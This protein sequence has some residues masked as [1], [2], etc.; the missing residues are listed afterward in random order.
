MRVDGDPANVLATAK[1]VRACW[2]EMSCGRR[3]DFHQEF[4]DS[5]AARCDLH[6]Y[7][8]GPRE[9]ERAGAV[10]RRRGR[11]ESSEG[12][13]LTL[14]GVQGSPFYPLRHLHLTK[15]GHEY[16]AS[17]R[18]KRIHPNGRKVEENWLFLVATLANDFSLRL[19]CRIG[20]AGQ[21]ATG[22]FIPLPPSPVSTAF[23]SLASE[24]SSAMKRRLLDLE[25]RVALA[26]WLL[27]ENERRD[28]ED[29][30]PRH[31]SLARSGMPTASAA[32][33]ASPSLR[34]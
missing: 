15:R 20:V 26:A 13:W 7:S 33:A 11:R 24:L 34:L 3:S 14:C 12:R 19:A 6:I 18:R 23:N 1:P 9:L 28:R 2:Q 29:I 30:T 10:P 31:G 27:G 16:A 5:A 22:L 8:G 25:L 21:A 4:V 17:W 32:A